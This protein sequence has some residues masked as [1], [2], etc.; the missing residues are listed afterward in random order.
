M[1]TY[2]RVTNIIE[3][4]YEG[5]SEYSFP[6]RFPGELYHSLVNKISD[7]LIEQN[8]GVG[9]VLIVKDDTN[10]IV[11][12]F[13]Y[14]VIKIYESYVYTRISEIYSV[15]SANLEKLIAVYDFENMYIITV[16]EKIIP[17]L[18]FN[19]SN[20]IINPLLDITMIYNDDI[21]CN[22][23]SALSCMHDIGFAHRDC[24][25]DNVGV[26]I[27]SDGNYIYVLF[28]YGL[29]NKYEDSDEFRMYIS[30]DMEILT[31]SI[32]R[33]LIR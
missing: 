24:Q 9:K 14:C 16:T 26:K 33:Y 28:D 25:L 5:F 4:L 27:D 23:S 15:N 10:V 6:G 8:R 31:N 12:I 3:S 22:I 11:I 30:R 19:I 17:L 7:I 20:N 13:D 32:T 1:T 21:F 18:Q 29:S 2:N